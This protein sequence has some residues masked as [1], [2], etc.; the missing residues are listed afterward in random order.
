[1]RR[2]L[3]AQLQLNVTFTHTQMRPHRG[4]PPPLAT[5]RLFRAPDR[6]MQGAGGRHEGAV[7][8]HEAY[9]TKLPA[10]LL[11][12]LHDS[13][14]R[15]WPPAI[16]KICHTAEQYPANL[17]PR[18]ERHILPGHVLPIS[19]RLRRPQVYIAS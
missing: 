5:L 15:R 6:G 14:V 1:M 8:P 4:N 3:H 16:R 11:K 18:A 10:M 13:V 19:M 9:A 17:Y 12:K 7:T 2:L